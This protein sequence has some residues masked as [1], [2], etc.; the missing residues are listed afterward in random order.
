MLEFSKK[1]ELIIFKHLKRYYFKSKKRNFYLKENIQ[2]KSF[3]FS[4]KDFEYFSKGVQKLT[5]SYTS[6]RSS[7]AKNYFND[8]VLRSGY[9]LYF[10]PVNLMKVVRIF[11]KIPLSIWGKKEIHILDI[12][13]GPGT[14]ALGIVYFLSHYLHLKGKLKI[15]FHLLDQN[16]HI[17]KDAKSLLESFETEFKD[18]EFSF[19]VL[20]YDSLS[21]V[22]S[23]LKQKINFL[24][25]GN[26]LNEFKTRDQQKEFVKNLM[27][28][29]LYPKNGNILIFEP[30]LKRQS[31]DLQYLR[32]EI[33]NGDQV[34]VLLPCVHQK[35]C[36]L[37]LANKRDWC[38]FYFSWKCPDFIRKVDKIVGNKKDWLASSYLFLSNR[39]DLDGD[40]KEQTEQGKLKLW[41]VI[42][43][44][45]HQ[46]G[47]TEIILCGEPGRYK[48][49]RLLRNESKL[50]KDFERMKRGDLVEYQLQSQSKGFNLDGMEVL[51]Q[52]SRIKIRT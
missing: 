29:F 27:E 33:L 39:L 4:G 2:N 26:V 7:L 22:D 30:A 1:L 21:K 9:L 28:R 45:I 35:N 46:K 24:I 44:K 51:N 12:G 34:K 41:R 17:L 40:Q 25:L 3:Q 15:H 18:L 52:E 47:K 37:N 42:S 36:P 5:Q 31:R 38:H 23:K 6:D 8:P 13:S 50:N 48:L 43:N 20:T 10:L 16:Q 19:K 14:S 49:T 32:D 11:E